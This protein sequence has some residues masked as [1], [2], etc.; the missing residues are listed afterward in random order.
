M[1]S[2]MPLRVEGEHRYCHFD[3][4]Y[5]QSNALVTD[6]KLGRKMELLPGGVGVGWGQ[7]P[8]ERQPPLLSG[9]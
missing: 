4:R 8:R 1:P 9:Y 3:S 7:L 5:H 6:Y 2:S